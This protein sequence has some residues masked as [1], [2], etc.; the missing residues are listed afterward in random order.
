MLGGDLYGKIGT[1]TI[2]RSCFSTSNST[3]ASSVYDNFFHAFCLIPTQGSGLAS[4]SLS[5]CIL[6]PEEQIPGDE[7]IAIRNGPCACEIRDLNMSYCNLQTIE[8][9]TVCEINRIDCFIHNNFVS[10]SSGRLMAISNPIDITLTN[11]ISNMKTKY[12]ELF[13]DKSRVL[14]TECT[15]YNNSHESIS[16]YGNVEDNGSFYSQNGFTVREDIIEFHV[17]TKVNFCDESSNFFSSET[18]MIEKSRVSVFLI[19]FLFIWM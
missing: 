19:I 12:T 4:L 3:A 5:T 15:L 11:L 2:D 16:L 17:H 6:C 18:K 14:L 7:T 13:E 9:L 10:S 1:L 8:L